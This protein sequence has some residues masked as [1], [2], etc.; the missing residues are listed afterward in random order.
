MEQKL[1]KASQCKRKLEL[2]VPEKQAEEDYYSVVKKYRKH[3]NID[4][5][6]KGKAPLSTVE[7]LL[8]DKL[9]IGFIEEFAPKYYKKALSKL[10]KDNVLPVNQAQLTNF[11]WDKGKDLILNFSFEVAPEI[12]L[13]EYKNFDVEYEQAKVTDEMIEAKLNELQQQYS[14]SVEKEGEIETGDLI[15]YTIQKLNGKDVEKKEDNGYKVGQQRFGEKF[16]NDLLGAKKG[17]VVNSEL[18]FKT[19]DDEGNEQ[20]KSIQIE[21]TSVKKV[22]MP[23]LDDEFAKDVGEYKNLAEL[24]KDVKEELAKQLEERN[25]SN[26]NASVLKAI[27][28]KNP[29]EVPQSL[30]ENYVSR[31][32][33]QSGQANKVSEEQMEQFKNM[34]RSYAEKEIQTYYVMKKLRELEEIEVSDDEIEKQ[35]KEDAQNANMEVEKYKKMYGKNIDKEQIKTRIKDKKILN[36]ISDTVNFKKPKKENK[37]KD[38]K[39]E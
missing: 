3:V 35:I 26:K 27:I 31:M 21:I 32:I 33:K 25:E 12:E 23:E 29:F 11:D 39:K 16:D 36:K 20:K 22:E 24:K 13:D 34:Y 6:R 30:V 14:Q 37:S 17:D 38:K 7:N 28:D 1:E 5:F 15:Y 19:K 9:K 2:T 10:E 8:K 18:Q 4:G